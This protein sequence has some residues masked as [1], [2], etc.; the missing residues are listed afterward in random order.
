MIRWFVLNNAD[1]DVDAATED[2]HQHDDAS[3]LHSDTEQE[4][5][6]EAQHEQHDYDSDSNFFM[7]A[8]FCHLYCIIH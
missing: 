3:V 7:S 5:D 8:M 6:R 4:A 2:T 1:S